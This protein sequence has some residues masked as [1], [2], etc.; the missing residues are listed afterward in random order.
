MGSEASYLLAILWEGGGYL[1]Y[2]F[3]VEILAEKFKNRARKFKIVKKNLP[4][5]GENVY[6]GKS[7]FYP[8][9]VGL[10]PMGGG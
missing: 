3:R 7:P 8:V 1:P 4:L 2:T 10:R 9:L 5:R 6:F